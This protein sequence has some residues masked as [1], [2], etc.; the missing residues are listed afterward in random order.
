MTAENKI[1]A[2]DAQNGHVQDRLLDAA[3][4]LFCEKGFDRTSVRDLTR[5]ANC[6]VA[7]VNYHFGGKDKLYLQMFKRQIRRMMDRQ[8][9]VIARIT[10]QPDATLEDLLR[11]AVSEALQ[12]LKSSEQSGAL[13]KLL[14]R[15]MLDRR[16]DNI[17]LLGEVEADFYGLF[18]EA[19]RKF[20]PHLT[21]RQMQL[22]FFS[23]D[24]LV[25]HPV[26]FHEFYKDVMPDLTVE[27]LVEHVVKVAAAGIR[28]YA[29]GG[30][31]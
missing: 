3:E 19:F 15:E 21:D 16:P 4:R 7:A 23:L 24:A 8:R 17:A 18:A 11:G 30:G 29:Q 31:Q 26:L 20:C 2:A 9:A 1:A 12:Q 28:A 25:A 5:A 22:L 6:N 13:M 27:D 14:A 10:A